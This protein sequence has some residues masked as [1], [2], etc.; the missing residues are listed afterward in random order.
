[1]RPD[2][3]KTSLD[4]RLYRFLSAE[5]YR[6]PHRTVIPKGSSGKYSM[7]L[8]EPRG[9]LCYYSHNGFFHRVKLDGTLI[10]TRVIT[11]HGT[12]AVPEYTSM[13]LDTNGVLHA[14][15]TTLNVPIRRYWGIPLRAVRRRWHDV[16]H[17]CR[18]TAPAA[19]HRGCSLV[20][21][22]QREFKLSRIEAETSLAAFLQMLA[23]R[24]LIR[25]EARRK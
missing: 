13:Q 15:W 2:W 17:L 25:L 7:V 18:H 4:V 19:H 12:M 23:S 24:G 14:A 16:E 20:A 8:D 3:S 11:K 9:R 22:L 6:E 5:D 10:D 21:A 1:M